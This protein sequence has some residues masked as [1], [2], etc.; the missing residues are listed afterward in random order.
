M[1]I[2]SK[3][4]ALLFLH[5]DFLSKDQQNGGESMEVEKVENQE[6]DLMIGIDQK[7]PPMQTFFYGVQ[8]VFVSNVWLDPIFVAAMVGMP[9][10]LATNIVNAIFIATGLV[11]LVQATKLVRLPIVQGPS[12]AF[13]SLMISTGKTGGL[14]AAGGGILLSAIII[15]LLSITGLIGKLRAL[16]TPVISGTVI[17]V[18]GVALSGF[19]LYEF[20]GGSAGTPTFATGTTL[21]MSIPTA[22][23]VIFL[24]IFGKKKWRSFA[25]LIAL[26]VGDMIATLLGQ[27][28]FSQVTQK[29]W[30]GLP[31]VFPYGHLVFHWDTFIMFFVAYIVAVIEAMGVYQ[32]GAEMTKVDL[33]AKRIRYGFAGE[34]VGSMISTVIG[35]FPTTAYGQNVGLLRLTG[36]GSRYPVMVA[37]VL[38]L[39]L[40]LVPKAGALLALTPDPVVGG[41]FLPAAASLIFTGI[42]ILMKMEKN[43]VNFTIAGMAILLAIALPASFSGVK[44]VVGTFLSNQVLVGTASALLLQFILSTI[45]SW[46]RKKAK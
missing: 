1:T 33:D 37:G 8:H 31:H 22:L 13:D 21:A 2:V 38:F 34:S 28:H 45:P 32:A 30:L 26:I 19:T 3:N 4:E 25:F 36:V 20:L 41:I 24:S 10:T 16:F 27:T 9:L 46:F 5:A 17:L 43:D 44:G 12:A 15:F 14:A 6:T 35:G 7:L 29:A 39:I 40:G 11:T 23:I 18:V 42:S